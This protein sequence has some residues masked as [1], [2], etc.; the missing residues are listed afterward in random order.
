RMQQSLAVKGDLGEVGDQFFL[1]LDCDT[2]VT[3]RFLVVCRVRERVGKSLG[4]RGQTLPVIRK[5]WKIRREFLADAQGA[6]KCRLCLLGTTLSLIQHAEAFIDRYQGVGGAV[7]KV[8]GL[9]TRALVTRGQRLST[10]Q[11]RLRLRRILFGEQA[12]NAGKPAELS[13]QMS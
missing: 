6:A 5:T 8:P 2:V 3:F 11:E 12:R 4:G 1:C 7:E 13:A 10:Q 9:S